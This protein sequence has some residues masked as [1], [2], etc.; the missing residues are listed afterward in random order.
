[1]VQLIDIGAN[2]AHD[3]F[4]SD[5]DEVL[6]RA[7][8]AGVSRMILTGSS[9][10]SNFDALRLARERPGT[11]W[12][13]AG[14]HPHHASDYSDSTHESIRSLL[15][16]P[17]VVAVGECGLDYFRNFSPPEA[18]R[19]AFERQLDLAEESGLPVFLHQRDAQQDFVDILKPRLPNLSRG[20]AH[21][22]TGN[23]EELCELLELDLY[24]GITG[25]IC[26]ERRGAHLKKSVRLIP[27]DRLM[28]LRKV[29]CL[30]RLGKIRN[31]NSKFEI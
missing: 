2:L 23:E 19:S 25:W 28:L 10:S 26:D 4:D 13:T 16:E 27:D 8:Q 9:E 7:R 31:R 29:I 11:L 24:I 14:L 3:S 22:F 5:R 21:C 20:V 1:M 18:Q 6:D 12:S 15:G 30:F 17:E